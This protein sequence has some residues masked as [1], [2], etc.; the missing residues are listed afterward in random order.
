ME[1]KNLSRRWTVDGGS[2][3]AGVDG[4]RGLYL[5]VGA[6]LCRVQLGAPGIWGRRLHG[7]GKGMSSKQ[8]KTLKSAVL[9]VMR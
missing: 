7:L 9:L 4:G 6:F 5:G 1:S 8:P 3:L 2:R